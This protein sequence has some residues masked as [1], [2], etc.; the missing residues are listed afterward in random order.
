MRSYLCIPKIITNFVAKY[1]FVF[2]QL[3]HEN[4]IAPIP[5]GKFFDFSHPNRGGIW[6]CKFSKSSPINIYSTLQSL[7]ISGSAFLYV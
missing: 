3:S 1:K 5:Q 6:C 7:F 4:S 2:S